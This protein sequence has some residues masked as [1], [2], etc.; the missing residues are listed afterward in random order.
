[1]EL[2]PGTSH[3]LTE[4]AAAYPHL[5]MMR[6]KKKEESRGRTEPQRRVRFMCYAWHGTWSCA[7][8]A[9]RARGVQGAQR[10]QQMKNPTLHPLIYILFSC[11]YLHYS[12]LWKL[13]S[14]L[15][16]QAA[17]IPIKVDV[18]PVPGNSCN[19]LLNYAPTRQFTVIDCGRV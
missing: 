12:P 16:T 13:R 4:L 11:G 19:D 18:Q 2:S 6:Y 10:L 14:R 3:R 7:G 1:M 9:P 17:S 5:S 8:G 15:K